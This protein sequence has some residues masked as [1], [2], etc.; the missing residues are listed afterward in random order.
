MPIG[1]Q[2]GKK[3]RW[4]AESGSVFPVASGSGIL[5]VAISPACPDV[6]RPRKFEDRPLVT[7]PQND[8]FTGG[9]SQLLGIS[10]PYIVYIVQIN[11]KLAGTDDYFWGFACVLALASS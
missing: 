7:P 3:T 4:F 11:G 10:H 8:I 1:W 6:C 5:S 2:T 9:K